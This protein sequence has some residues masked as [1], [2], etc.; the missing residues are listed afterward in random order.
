[1]FTLILCEESDFLIGTIAREFKLVSE[2]KERKQKQ[3]SVGAKTCRFCLP[4][5][6]HAVS[7]ILTLRKVK[8]SF[9]S[10]ILGKPICNV[11]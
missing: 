8:E 3:I 1:M 5:F 9:Y 10:E 6:T 2:K 11:A 4:Q 7:G